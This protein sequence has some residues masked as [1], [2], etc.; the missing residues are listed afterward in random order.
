VGRE[1]VMECYVVDRNGVWP[2]DKYRERAVW[3]ARIC[4]LSAEEREVFNREYEKQ[5]RYVSRKLWKRQ[6][7]MNE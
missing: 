6:W 4:Y 3:S 5:Y 2:K 7:A 1:E